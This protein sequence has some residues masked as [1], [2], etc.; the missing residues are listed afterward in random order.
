M[1]ISVIT[2]CYNAE[3]FIADALE[4]ITSQTYQNLELVIVDGGSDDG[5]LDIIE[6]Y[7]PR[8]GK[9]V[10]ER[11]NGIYDAMNKAVSM[12]TGDYVLFMNTDDRFAS[13]T[14]LED[15]VG[16]G[17]SGDIVYGDAIYL[18]VEA[19]TSDH[20]QFPPVSRRFFCYDNLCHQAVLYRRTVFQAVGPFDTQFR[21][22]ADY[23]WFLRAF[24]KHNLTFKHVG[25]LMAI[26]RL[27]GFSKQHIDLFV[28]ENE[29]VRGLYYSKFERRFYRQLLGAPHKPAEFV[30]WLPGALA[31]QA[32]RTT[33]IAG[34]RVRSCSRSAAKLPIRILRRLR[35]TFFG[36][37]Q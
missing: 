20:R 26:Y 3:P 4:S 23:E 9:F 27:G 17:I 12:A 36:S 24:T 14:A 29:E 31:R 21:V 34:H 11:D 32:V 15:A 1:K 35:R 13:S 30:R 22:V 8:I 37:S 25:V 7:R 33:K 28:Q 6:Q 5:T 10:S 16:H 18:D 2:V 19:G